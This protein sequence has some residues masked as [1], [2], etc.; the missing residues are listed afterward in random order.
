VRTTARRPSLSHP[1]HRC[2]GGSPRAATMGIHR[3]ED[4]ALPPA[5]L[6]FWAAI[7]GKRILALVPSLDPSDSLLQAPRLSPDCFSHRRLR[8]TCTSLN[9]K[10]LIPKS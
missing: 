9:L 2:L 10:K 7:N 1:R 8:Q 5:R 4:S 6:T 3:K